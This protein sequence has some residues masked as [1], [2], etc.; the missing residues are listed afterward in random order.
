MKKEDILQ[1]EADDASKMG[2]NGKQVFFTKRINGKTV[3]NKIGDE[4]IQNT[5]PLTEK[6]E[7]IT[8]ELYVE[9]KTN[10][11]QEPKENTNNKTNLKKKVKKKKR[12]NKKRNKKRKLAKILFLIILLVG[13]TI[14]AMMSP[15]FKIEK[16]EISGNKQISNETI[17]SFANIHEGSNIFRISKK[18]VSSR[19][20]ENQYINNV[21]IK[22]KLPGVLKIEVEERKIAYQVKVIDS[23]IYIDYQGYILEVSSENANV[24][25]VEGLATDQDTLLNGKRLANS[26]INS[27]KGMLKIMDAA[28]AAEISN[29]ISKIKLEKVGY[30]L[31]LTSENKI[32]YLGNASNITNK[33]MYLKTILSKEK[34]HNG[35]IFLNGDLNTGF[36]PYFREETN[37]QEEN[38]EESKNESKEQKGEKDE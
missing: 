10:K 23:F 12:K 15:I 31:E 9:F 19:I 29:L 14:F 37:N 2:I 7:N 21:I 24:P 22:R 30:T 3:H 17:I 11:Y 6:N 1:F 36:K 35:K 27:L 20:K 32:V 16:I 18:D 28:K 26:D 25:L 8:E 4:E 34:G 5:I 38:T 33:M 13:I